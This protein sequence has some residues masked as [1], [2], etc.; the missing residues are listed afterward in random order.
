M[1]TYVDHNCSITVS[2]D[3]SEVKEIKEWLLTYWDDFVGVSWLP[4]INPKLTAVDLGFPY[5]PQ[6]VVTEETYQEYV[7]SLGEVDLEGVNIKHVYT[8]NLEDECDSGACP[9]I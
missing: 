5:L 7:D 6:E 9:V 3:D 8:D 1:N 4:R 2:Y